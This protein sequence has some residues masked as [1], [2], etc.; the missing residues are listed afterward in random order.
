MPTRLGSPI[1]V[2]LPTRAQR[3]A[4]LTIKI[5]RVYVRLTTFKIERCG[6]K[7]VRETDVGHSTLLRLVDA[8]KMFV[9]VVVVGGSTKLKIEV[10]AADD[11]IRSG[12]TTTSGKLTGNTSGS[13][14]REGG[15][16]TFSI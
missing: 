8:P 1:R 7:T 6:M 16:Y 2:W 12:C 14:A 3:D 11:A 4:A 15:F 10:D 13:L 5:A 9:G